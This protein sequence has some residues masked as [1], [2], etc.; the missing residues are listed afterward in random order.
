MVRTLVHKAAV[1]AAFYLLLLTALLTDGLL[2]IAYT[3]STIS[4]LTEHTIVIVQAS[5]QLTG[6]LAVAV[7][8]AR[9]FVLTREDDDREQA[10]DALED[11]RLL[12]DRITALERTGAG[13]LLVDGASTGLVTRQAEVAAA[14]SAEVEAALVLDATA[15]ADTVAMRSAALEALEGDIERLEEEVATVLDA[16]V[17]ALTQNLAGESQ[18]EFIATVGGIGVLIVASLALVWLL[19]RAVIRPVTQLAA[20]ARGVID[21]QLA[22]VPESGSRDE[23]GDLQRSYNQMVAALARQQADLVAHNAEL[24]QHLATQRDLL[25][26]V[27]ALATPLLPLADGVLVLPIVGHVDRARAA[28]LTETLLNG[29]A[30]HHA[31]AAILDVTG[32]AVVDDTV[33]RAILMAVDAGRLLGAE[34]LVAGISADMARRL[35][36]RDLTA[37]VAHAYR[38]VGAALRAY[39]QGELAAAERAG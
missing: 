12:L 24:E 10:E 35:G 25:A 29:I 39:Q 30:Q 31:R 3:T 28:A 27:S 2:S 11:A 22:P 36:D 21:G 4:D 26:T 16:K 17:A 13:E 15:G 20:A 23:I 38:D 5:H 9:M 34:V 14:V 8:E 6:E 7:G 19:Q 33:V 37:S 32:L 1:A 18:V